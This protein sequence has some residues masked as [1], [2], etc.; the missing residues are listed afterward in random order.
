MDEKGPRI[1]YGDRHFWKHLSE[2]LRRVQKDLD[3]AIKF[4]DEQL[5]VNEGGGNGECTNGSSQ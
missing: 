5:K 4:V 1:Y 2:Y 3:A